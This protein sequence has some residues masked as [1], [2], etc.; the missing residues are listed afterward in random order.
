MLLAAI[1]MLGLL[2]ANQGKLAEA[3][4]MY[5][6]VLRGYEEAL[7]P[8]HTLTLDTLNN[9]GNLYA[10]QG[11]TA[12]VEQVHER[13]LRGR[14]GAEASQLTAIKGEKKKPAIGRLFRKVFQWSTH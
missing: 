9:L 4:Q 11:K 6:R 14:L 12:K 2:C 13:V 10:D 1:H 8:N 3:E 7:G 5:E